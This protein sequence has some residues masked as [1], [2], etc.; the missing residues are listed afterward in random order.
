[1]MAKRGSSQHPKS[2][3]KAYAYTYTLFSEGCLLLLCQ[4]K[5]SDGGCEGEKLENG[6]GRESAEVAIS[7]V[8]YGTRS[9]KQGLR[10]RLRPRASSSRLPRR[11]VPL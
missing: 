11:E 7:S 3:T 5:R 2:N 4:G 8:G 10:L 9:S 6:S 1:M